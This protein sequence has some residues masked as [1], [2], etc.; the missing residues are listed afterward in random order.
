MEGNNKGKTN[1]QMNKKPYR[2]I[3]GNQVDFGFRKVGLGK[4]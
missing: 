1:E 4:K 3:Y 2:L